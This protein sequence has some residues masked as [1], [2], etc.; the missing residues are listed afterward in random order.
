MLSIL[1]LVLLSGFIFS[2]G[3]FSYNGIFILLIALILYFLILFNSKYYQKLI[4]TADVMYLI[5][6]ILS[7]VVYGGL[8][9][10]RNFQFIISL[11]LLFLNFLIAFYF[12]FVRKG[13]DWK[14]SFFLFSIIIMCAVR[15]IMV[16]SSPEPYIDVYDYLK[17][18][19]L[20]FLSLQN[21]Y[22][23][24]YQKLYMDVTPDFYSYLP[25]MII[26]T[27]PFVFLFDDPRY[28]FIAAEILAAILVYRLK[29]DSRNREIFSLLLLVNPVSAYMIEQSYTEP[30]LLFYLVLLIWAFTEKKILLASFITGLAM[31]TK[32]YFFLVLPVLLRLISSST[33]IFVFA[34]QAILF[35]LIFIIPFFF[36]NKEDFIHDA[37]LLQYNFPPRYEGLSFFSFLYHLFGFEYNF[38][39]SFVVIF[40]LLV[41]IYLQKKISISR[42][43]F[44]TSFIFFIVF[45]FNKWAFI[46]YYYL[47]AQTLLLSLV[48]LKD[49]T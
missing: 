29:K 19:A 26:V 48:F 39:Y 7:I 25:G 27:S 4:I 35:A 37:I 17:K 38:I 34:F 24:T 45:F 18:G 14:M 8:Y 43:Y 21:P 13:R 2:H 9:Q 1:Y 46:N 11:F 12:L 41:I 6:T 49:K 28:T 3:F 23:M 36:W 10:P 15:V 40:F 20:G 32:Q 33:K 30:L 31:A 47:I 42:F 22:S 5:L 16:R 44:L